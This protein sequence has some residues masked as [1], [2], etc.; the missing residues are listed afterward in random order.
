MITQAIDRLH[1]AVDAR[2]RVLLD[3]IAVLEKQKRTEFEER[4]MSTAVGISSCAHVNEL[5]SRAVK[6][7][8]LEVARAK[9]AV[10]ARLTA[11]SEG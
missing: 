2:T 10:D 5:V 7:P 3:S 8:D 11:K 1:A 6:L 9:A 4:R